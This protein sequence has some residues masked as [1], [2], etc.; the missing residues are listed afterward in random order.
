MFSGS[1]RPNDIA[2]MR[3]VLNDWC[4]LHERDPKSPEGVAAALKLLDLMR[5]R[6]LT[7]QQLLRGLEES[8]VWPQ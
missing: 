8:S 6:P 3:D 5:D 1:Y 7:Y 2:V 4:T